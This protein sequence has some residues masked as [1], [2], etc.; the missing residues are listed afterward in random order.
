MVTEIVKFMGLF[1]I[2]YFYFLQNYSIISNKMLFQI[3]TLK[4]NIS[5]II[6]AHLW[7]IYEDFLYVY[8]HEFVYLI[9]NFYFEIFFL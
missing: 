2:Y 7:S 9:Q 4:F 3:V 1:S 5:S 8:L 6:C